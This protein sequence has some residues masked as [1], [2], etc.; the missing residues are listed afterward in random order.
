MVRNGEPTY[1]DHSDEEVLGEGPGTL[2]LNLL[3]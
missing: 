2:T 1:L 3:K